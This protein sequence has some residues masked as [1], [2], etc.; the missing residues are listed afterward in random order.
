MRSPAPSQQERAIRIAATLA[1]LA[2][3]GLPA[4]ASEPPPAAPTAPATVA[5]APQNAFEADYAAAMA[6]MHSEVASLKQ[7]GN[8]DVAYVQ[9]MI[10]QKK[11][12]IALS[13][14]A[15][16]NSADATVKRM[17]QGMINTQQ[18]EIATLQRWVGLHGAASGSG[19]APVSKPATAAQP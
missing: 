18:R 11:A 15:M 8:S 16:K 1:L 2:C 4:C 5:V 14:S 6:H 3:A 13:E 12:S 9:H 19:A 17:A 10:A 7:T